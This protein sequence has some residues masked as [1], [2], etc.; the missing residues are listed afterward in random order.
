MEEGIEQLCSKATENLNPQELQQIIRRGKNRTQSQG[1]PY[2]GLHH[3]G[4]GLSE[5]YTNKNHNN[6]DGTWNPNKGRKAWRKKH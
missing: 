4:E 5:S 2:Q 6:S 3:I 1:T